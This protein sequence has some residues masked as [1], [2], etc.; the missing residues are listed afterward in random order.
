MTIPQGVTVCHRCGEQSKVYDYWPICRE[1]NESVCPQCAAGP[2]TEYDLDQPVTTLCISCAVRQWGVRWHDRAES[3][4]G[5]LMGALIW[6][7]V[8]GLFLGK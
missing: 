3:L 7:A 8:A 5:Y 6:L 1:C 2:I 4:G